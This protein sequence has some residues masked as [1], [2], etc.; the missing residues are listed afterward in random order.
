MSHRLAPSLCGLPQELIDK[1]S[2][3]LDNPADLSNLSKTCKSM[4]QA[5][6]NS[7][8]E[9]ITMLWKGDI[10]TSQQI[11]NPRLDLLLRTLLEAPELASRVLTADL[12]ATG[13]RA[14]MCR[15]VRPKLPAPI[16]S[17][18]QAD[19]VIVRLGLDGT[20]TGNLLKA[21]LLENDFDAILAVFVLSCPKLAHLTLGL[22]V[23]F[24]NLF[25][26]T[27]LGAAP[28]PKSS[29]LTSE[30]QSLKTLKLGAS[31]DP[32]IDAVV[33]YIGCPSEVAVGIPNLH[34]YSLLFYL[35]SL[36][37]VEISLP[38]PWP[39]VEFYWPTPAPPKLS[40]LTSLRLLEST[41]EPE[42][43]Q[44]ILLATPCLR[45]LQY[46]CRMFPADVFD[47]GAL[48]T[49]LDAVKNTLVELNV[50]GKFWSAPLGEPLEAPYP[51]V[52]GSCSLRKMASLSTVSMP[53]CVLL[54]WDP[55]SAPG[56][57]GVLPPDIVGLRIQDDCAEYDGYAWSEERLVLQIQDFVARERW[58]LVTPFL[59]SVDVSYG[60][61]TDGEA[62]RGLCARNGLTG[63][64]GPASLATP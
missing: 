1:I 34:T 8:Y 57:D 61:W 15:A 62:L 38:R 43:L 5:T 51:R 53:S 42:T 44:H 9:N 18:A 30:F 24:A 22:D 64:V 48:E 16:C 47:A 25:I 17:T 40:T 2:S 14:T 6:I 23:L 3:Q 27:I 19:Q 28:P 63:C 10:Y 56:L 29:K 50:G 52:R 33:T 46:D 12:Q 58:K 59:R 41:L 20:E 31:F 60:S 11:E 13:L 37:H 54:G 4:R 21:R 7:L 39:D 35:P 49:A 26:S 55:A 32:V 36:E 45:R